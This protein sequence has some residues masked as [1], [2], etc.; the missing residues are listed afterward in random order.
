LRPARAIP[1]CSSSI[2]KQGLARVGALGYG[3]AEGKQTK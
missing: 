2:V 1:G 3:L